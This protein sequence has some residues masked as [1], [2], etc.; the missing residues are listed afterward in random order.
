[1]KTAQLIPAY[2]EYLRGCGRSPFTIKGIR[3]SLKNFIR[4]LES[5]NLTDL[6]EL[7]SQALEEYRADLAFSL[8]AK[9]TPLGRQTQIQILCNVKGFTAFLKARDYLLQDPAE[10]L[11]VPKQPQRLPK[12]ILTAKE[13]EKL[14]N[15]PDMRTSRGYRNRIILEILYDT[16][17][18]RAE[19][20]EIKLADLDLNGGYIRITGKGDKDRVVPVSARVCELIQNYLLFVRPEFIH[21]KDPGHLVLNRWGQRL[22]PN[23]VWAVVHRS[24]ALAGIKKTISTHTLRHSCATHMLKNG[25]P[26]R[27]IQEMLGHAS[28][29]TTQIYTRVTIN[30]LKQVHSQ[31]HPSEQSK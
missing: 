3:S 13:V 14:L 7:T 15:A 5:E 9:G 6:E 18:R 22:D 12:A 20:S 4:F 30:D 17:I 25:A 11:T 28:I 8:T 24:V 26:V 16:G 21:D 31:Y 1:M 10:G 2:I 19:V 27:H 23:G 29:N